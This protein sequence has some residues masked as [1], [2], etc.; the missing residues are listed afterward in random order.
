MPTPGPAPT[1]AAPSPYLQHAV[2]LSQTAQQNNAP[3][4]ASAIRSVA[5]TPH[6]ADKHQVAMNY[7]KTQPPAVA[8]QHQHM[9]TQTLMGG[10]Q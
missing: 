7:L 3:G 1:P 10:G 9:F 8:Q 5:A 2:A 4:L 6:P